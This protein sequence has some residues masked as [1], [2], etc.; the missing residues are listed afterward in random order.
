MSN[1]Y[2]YLS[3]SKQEIK[4]GLRIY[5]FPIDDADIDTL[6]FFEHEACID[7]DK[8]FAKK[9]AASIEFVYNLMRFH[10]AKL[11]MINRRQAKA[12]CRNACLLE[13]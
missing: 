1:S 11:F 8:F 5:I 4:Q 6:H 2:Y 10:D 12:I 7:P 13:T 3:Y 9:D